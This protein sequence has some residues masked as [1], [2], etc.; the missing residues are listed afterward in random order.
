MGLRFFRSPGVVITLV[1]AGVGVLACAKGDSRQGGFVDAVDVAPTEPPPPAQ[2]LPSTSS[3]GGD[4]SGASSTSSSSSSSSGGTDS[5]TDGSSGGTDAGLDAAKDASVDAATDAGSTC[6]TVPPTNACGLAP[7]CGCGA[8]QTCDVTNASNGGVSCVLAGGGTLGSFCTSTSQCLKGTT[9]G[10]NACRPYCPTIGT[11]CVG[12][13][14]G[15]CAQYYD[16]VAGTP[17]PNSKVCSV[18][19]DLRNP[20][21]ACGANNCIWDTTVNAADCDKSGTKAVYAACTRYNDCQQGMACAKHPVFGFECEKWCRIGQNDC[22]LFDSCTDVYGATAPT[23]GG[24][25]LGHCQ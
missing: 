9:C 25:K 17:V 20:S 13:G 6:A 22:G 23:S 11:A 15:P 18:T 12:A 5:G 19:C 2:P 21:A 14:L 3:S 7:Q 8:T 24:A 16:P 1:L 4:D 10:Y